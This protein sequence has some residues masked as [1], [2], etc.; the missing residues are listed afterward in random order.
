MKLNEKGYKGTNERIGVNG[1]DLKVC[2]KRIGCNSMYDGKLYPC[3]IIAYIRHL[4]K[5][6]NTNFVVT[7][8]DYLD[9]Y[10]VKKPKEIG[11]FLDTPE[12]PF[13]NY[14]IVNSGEVAWENSK[15][16]TLNEWT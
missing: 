6:F 7:E 3:F 14:C 1:I 8:K 9:L 11:E 13:C 15:E 5:K 16:H 12:F 2:K 10:K 4:N